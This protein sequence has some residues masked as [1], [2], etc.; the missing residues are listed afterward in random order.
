[1]KRRFKVLLLALV[2]IFTFTLEGFAASTVATSVEISETEIKETTPPEEGETPP[3]DEETP[4]EEG[5]TPPEEVETPPEDEETPPEAMLTR[6][7]P[8]P[9]NG[10]LEYPEV[11]EYYESIDIADKT[12][13]EIV[14]SKAVQKCIQYPLDTP[15]KEFA[16]F[17]LEAI[18]NNQDL[19]R[20]N[21]VELSPEEK[22]GGYDLEGIE[23][24]FPSLSVIDLSSSN[25][26]MMTIKNLG[27]SKE[28]CNG[29]NQLYLGNLYFEESIYDDLANYTSLLELYLDSFMEYEDSLKEAPEGFGLLTDFSFI[30]NFINLRNANISGQYMPD[31]N[32][33]IS[34][35]SAL[36]DIDLSSNET[37]K[38]SSF[39]IHEELKNLILANNKIESLSDI[40]IDA[41]KIVILDISKNHIIDFSNV[42]NK[43]PYI[44]GLKGEHQTLK[45]PI[46]GEIID[47]KLKLENPTK[48]QNGLPLAPLAIYNEK[49]ECIIFDGEDIGLGTTSTTAFYEEPY[50]VWENIEEKEGILRFEFSERLFDMSEE[51]GERMFEL[52]GTIDVSFNAEDT[53][54]ITYH[55]NNHT[56]GEPPVDTKEYLADSTAKVA[57]KHTLEKENHKFIGWNTQQNGEGT[58]FNPAQDIIVTGNVNLYAQWEKEQEPDIPD[59]DTY[60]I[61]Y[62]GNNHTAGEPPTDTNKYAFEDKG[63]V[64]DKH[65]LEKD[66]HKFIGWNTQQNGEGTHFNPAEDITVKGHT[67]LF[68]QWEKQEKPTTPPTNPDRPTTPEKP[69]QPNIKKETP[70]LKNEPEPEEYKE[71]YLSTPGTGGGTPLERAKMLVER[72]SFFIV[73]LL[74]LILAVVVRFSYD[75]KITKEE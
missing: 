15:L 31:M 40:N 37:K 69:D 44:T 2:V 26:Y 67:T 50:I 56:A 24:L 18:Y 52:G 63:S 16:K 42:I 19:R 74:L 68:A 45:E 25:D 48:N 32:L 1:M 36:E 75:D 64:A 35:L 65:T 11:L 12:I 59:E 43:F 71:T 53:Y 61:T 7:M 49:N 30:E 57:D 23:E 34:N 54:S 4:P 10:P 47:G 38:I 21:I 17:N 55:G 33:D 13:R 70:K 58:P 41:K 39:K 62:H 5:V 3:E 51:L 73:A 9:S 46:I 20:D 6:G 66:D 22:R 14:P 8:V 60:S 72:Q 27:F 29:I 28:Y